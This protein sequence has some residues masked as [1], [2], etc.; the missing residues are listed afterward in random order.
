MPYSIL[1][2]KMSALIACVEIPPSPAVPFTEIYSVASLRLYAI[3][4]AASLYRA[5]HSYVPS[6]GFRNPF[7]CSA[8]TWLMMPKWMVLRLPFICLPQ[9]S[10]THCVAILLSWRRYPIVSLLYSSVSSGSKFVQSQPSAIH[11][12]SSSGASIAWS[13]SI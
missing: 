11:S 4:I 12:C 1:L 6:P 13:S 9:T 2:P 10:Q 7:L 5:F 8:L 3:F